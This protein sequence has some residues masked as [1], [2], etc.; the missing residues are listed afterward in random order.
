MRKIDFYHFLSF[1]GRSLLILTLLLVSCATWKLE[2]KLDNT[3]KDWYGL[4]WVLM[5]EKVPYWIE[6][7][8][9]SERMHFL[10]LPLEMQR[11]YIKIF[12]KIRREGA[13]E[14]F[15]GRVEYANRAFTGEGRDGWKTDRGRVFILCGM[16]TYIE[17][18]QDGQ[19][20]IAPG[21]ADSSYFQVWTYYDY[22]YG[23]AVYVFECHM[24][25]TWRISYSSLR[26]SSSHQYVESY[27]K[28]LF[29]VTDD[30]WDLWGS[31]LL[32]WVKS[33]K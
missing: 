11:E 6:E 14:C 3:I 13:R 33:K 16:P 25:E 5:Q 9:P 24:P 28:R 12:W 26:M 2:R 30:G 1:I 7:G 17:W 4:H 32:D 8:Q 29:A 23:Y 18:Y 31:I 22:A 10:R 19:R 20:T 27:W 21:M 15:Y